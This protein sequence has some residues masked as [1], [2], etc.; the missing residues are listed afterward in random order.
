[1]LTRICPSFQQKMK[2]RI[3]SV[4]EMDTSVIYAE[5]NAV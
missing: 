2:A 3:H 5:L 4:Y 1:M